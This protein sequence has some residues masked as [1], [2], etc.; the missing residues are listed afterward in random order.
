MKAY[1]YHG[2]AGCSLEDVPA[3]QPQKDE[4]LIKVKYCGICG[5]DHHIKEGDFQ[6][7]EDLILGHEF[8]GVVAGTGSGVEDFKQGD[9]VV[10]DPMTPCFECDYCQT[11][12][13]HYCV[14]LPGIGVNK[15]GAFA[16]YITVPRSNVHRLQ[17][18]TPF[19]VGAFAEPLSCCLH[20]IDQ[21]NI[22]QGEN[23]VVI[24]DGAIGL[25]MIQL[26]RLA[27][28]SDLVLVG[29]ID[30]RREL[31]LKLGADKFFNGTEPDV[32]DR[33]TGYFQGKQ[34]NN[35]IEAV[36]LKQTLELSLE[37]K[38]YGSRLLWFGVPAPDLKIELS[39]QQIF[40]KEIKIMGSLMNPYTAKRAVRLLDAGKVDVEPLIS[41]RFKLEDIEQAF[42]V[43]END[44]QRIKI[45]IEGE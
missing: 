28:V 40:E 44:E 43:Y 32:A 31:A 17:E 3:P 41:H 24:G 8:S 25:M 22:D 26:A 35:I 5:T 15:D 42:E 34:I 18:D 11:G 37:I 20:G 4:V 9:H 27:G 30:S 7:K 6:A 33:I 13:V 39:P 19:E 38:T 29:G 10:G 12:Q 21:L 2:E 1:V 45:M 23:A 16:E 14:E 36:G